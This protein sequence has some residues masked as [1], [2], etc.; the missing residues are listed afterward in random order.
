MVNG[1]PTGRSPL[2]SVGQLL[3]DYGRA[4]LLTAA[5]EIHLATLYRQGLSP[6]ASAGQRRASTRAKERMI[7]A[8]LRLVI[9]IARGY[10]RRLFGQGLE[11][12]DLAQEGVLG[13]TRAVEKFDPAKGYKF[14]TY[15]TWWI[16][17]AISR[18][19]D[20]QG[21]GPIRVSANQ[22]Q[23]LRKLHYAP[24]GLNPQELMAYLGVSQTQFDLLLHARR[25]S[26]V[27]SLDAAFRQ[28]EDGSG[29]L[30]DLVAD[31]NAVDSLAELDRDLILER[32]RLAAD[33]S[34][35]ELVE[36]L[37]TGAATLG[38]LALDQGL[39]RQVITNRRNAAVKRLRTLAGDDTRALLAS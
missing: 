1:K 19:L 20:E 7:R 27:S 16:R 24:P 17:Q 15:A 33:P 12:Q 29:S 26:G 37:A 39:S 28:S 31:P 34:D 4:P 21:G 13:L 5:A 14:S 30:L 22:Q 3:N 10:R 32:L 9:S 36:A 38:E 2:D 18:H 6:E 35:L 23:Q 11:F 8:N 25:L